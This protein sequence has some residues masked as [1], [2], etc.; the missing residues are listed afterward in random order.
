[1]K[2]VLALFVAMLACASTPSPTRCTAGQVSVCPCPGGGAGSQ[3][4]GP[5]GVFS[6]CMCVGADAGPDVALDVP[7]Q[8]DTPPEV[9]ADVPAELGADV[10]PDVAEAAVDVAADLPA[11]ASMC[12]AGFGDCDAVA[13]NG[14]ETN[15]MTARS[16][17][18]RCGNECDGVIMNASPS[19]LR[20]VCTLVCASGYGD[21]D[22]R[23]DTGCETR[24]ATDPNNCGTCR[25]S[26]GA[27]SCVMGRCT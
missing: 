17:C 21:C 14:C 5:D 27:R 8:A 24:I 3:A 12:P 25:N 22:G 11:E 7:V 20:G 15:L 2:I 26:C 1:M 16:N 13:S 4:C 18:G 6:A 10:I 9:A 19:C 23:Y